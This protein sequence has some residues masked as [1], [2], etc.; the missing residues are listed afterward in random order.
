[1][2][3]LRAARRSFCRSRKRLC[4]ED[5]ASANSYRVNTLTTVRPRLYISGH[6]GC[7]QQQ[8][9]S[10]QAQCSLVCV[11]LGTPA[12][13]SLS[14]RA[15]SV[16]R[17]AAQCVF[18]GTPAA[19]STSCRASSVQHSTASQ[20]TQR[21]VACLSPA[22]AS[23][24]LLLGLLALVLATCSSPGAVWGC[25]SATLHRPALLSKPCRLVQPSH[26]HSILR[27]V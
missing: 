2:E 16:K 26:H 10:W 13:S 4:T 17:S 11:S 22:I 21:V 19:S 3:S 14:C 12:A 20:M 23:A 6:T 1:M 24:L 15:S 9:Q 5:A 7:I 25:L 27:M 8:L 18:Q